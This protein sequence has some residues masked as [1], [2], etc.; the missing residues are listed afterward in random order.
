[1]RKKSKIGQNIECALNEL[2]GSEDESSMK[3]CKFIKTCEK[4]RN[5]TNG[6]DIYVRIMNN[7]IKKLNCYIVD[8]NQ[9][10]IKCF[11]AS[12]VYRY[13][14]NN[15]FKIFEYI[16]Y[17]SEKAC[18]IK[19]F[20]DTYVII[21]PDSFESLFYQNYIQVEKSNENVKFT[22]DIFV[23]ENTDRRADSIYFRL[24]DIDCPIIFTHRGNVY[25]FSLDLMHSHWIITNDFMIKYYI[26]YDSVELSIK[27]FFMN[28]FRRYN[29]AVTT[30]AYL[31]LYYKYENE[32]DVLGELREGNI[33][34][35]RTIMYHIKDNNSLNIID[36]K[37]IGC[38]DKKT[39][40]FVYFD[41]DE[42]HR[43]FVNGKKDWLCS[44]K[45]RFGGRMPYTLKINFN[46]ETYSFL[47][48]KGKGIFKCLFM[49]YALRSKSESEENGTLPF[50]P[51]DIFL[52]IL[53][54]LFKYSNSK[55][56]MN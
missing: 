3:K 14:C 15:L 42:N 45:P 25:H 1:M 34:G 22:D 6:L 18:I 24:K 30:K 41:V 28:D 20:E 39:D 4:T 21:R 29:S 40:S 36:D 49:C 8:E 5:D 11:E 26:D 35:L 32:L 54:Y 17:F 55:Y 56:I 31:N 38:L 2:L 9:N 37:Y 10:I 27:R 7:N 33:E 48:Q 43:L 50:L 19:C 12:N 47:N 51:L 13:K 16:V 44:W 23:L 53:E 46:Y 52:Y